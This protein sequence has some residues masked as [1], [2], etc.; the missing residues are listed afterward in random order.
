MIELGR[1]TWDVHFVSWT[2]S[3]QLHNLQLKR[4]RLCMR[5]ETNPIVL[6]EF[7]SLWIMF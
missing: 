1:L 6:N 3:E 4:H 5:T 2:P 7:D